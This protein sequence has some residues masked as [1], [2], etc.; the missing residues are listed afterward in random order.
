MDRPGFGD[1]CRAEAAEGSSGVQDACCWA[2]LAQ[3]KRLAVVAQFT[4]GMADMADFLAS[5][6]KTNRSSVV[7]D[8]PVKLRVHVGYSSI[9]SGPSWLVGGSSVLAHICPHR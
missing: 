6:W 2:W 8:K 7:S 5:P 9:D 3:P 1:L 4:A